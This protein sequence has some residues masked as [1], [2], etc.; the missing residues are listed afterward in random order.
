MS[1]K[2]FI[3]LLKKT[4]ENVKSLEQKQTVYKI[5]LSYVRNGKND[6]EV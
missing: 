4:W 1:L 5:E 3:I 6:V 2:E